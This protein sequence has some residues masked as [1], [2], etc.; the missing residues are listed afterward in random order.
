MRNIVNLTLIVIILVVVVYLIE[1]YIIST[2]EVF[3]HIV[4][5]VEPLYVYLLF[6]LSESFLGLIPPDLF[7][8]WSEPQ[9]ISFGINKWWL[10]ALLAVLSYLG[11]L[12]S[13]LIGR[14]TAKIPVVNNW[15]LVKNQKIFI[16]LQK[17]GGFF[18]VTAALFPLPYS[19]VTLLAGMTS[20]PIRWLLVLGI[21]R[22][23]RF[24]VYAIFLFYI[25]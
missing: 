11:G 10:V 12:L 21:F 1:R 6:T 24:F 3:I 25:F 13:F 17:W 9:A 14:K 16:Y 20:Y 8:V 7:I 4:D 2:K 18:I 5:N 15:L 23:V 19:M 22:I